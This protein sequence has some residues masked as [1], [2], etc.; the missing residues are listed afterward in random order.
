MSTTLNKI[1]SDWKLKMFLDLLS[2]TNL[3]KV[4]KI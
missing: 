3:Y 2:K 1:W 4:E